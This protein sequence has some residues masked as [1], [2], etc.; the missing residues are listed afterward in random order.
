MANLQICKKMEEVIT[1]AE[2][3]LFP[4]MKSVNRVKILGTIP[5]CYALEDKFPMDQLIRYD[6][7]TETELNGEF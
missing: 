4:G 3:L 5:Q 7:L 1:D 6:D 2:Q